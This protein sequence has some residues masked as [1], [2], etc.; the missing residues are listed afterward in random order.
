MMPSTGELFCG[1]TGQYIYC[2]NVVIINESN[3]NIYNI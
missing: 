3:L 1:K 2:E